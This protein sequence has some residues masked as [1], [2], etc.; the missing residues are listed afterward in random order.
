L[1]CCTKHWWYCQCYTTSS[2]RTQCSA[3][4]TGWI[5]PQNTI[6][7][8]NLNRLLYFLQTTVAFDTGPGNVFIDWC[9]TQISQGWWYFSLKFVVLVTS[10]FLT[11][12]WDVLNLWLGRQ[13]FDENG[14]FASQ[15]R[16]NIE[17]LQLM[18]SHTYFQLPPPKTT[19]R[20][21]FTFSVSLLI[22]QMIKMLFSQILWSLENLRFKKNRVFQ[23]E[24]LFWEQAI[25]T[26]KENIH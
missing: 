24:Y 6:A 20:E 17:L 22:Q 2:T 12:V 26:N 19:G 1:A 15:G 13:T 3:K 23:W 16:V 9:A 5:N 21:L 11:L 4:Y 25:K 7:V 8:S 14:R 10:W 18:E